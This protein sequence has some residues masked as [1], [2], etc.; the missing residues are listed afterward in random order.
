MQSMHIITNVTSSNPA[1]AMYTQYNNRHY[2][3]NFVMLLATEGRR[4]R[5]RTVVGLKT[6]YAISAYHHRCCKFESSSGEVYSIQ[7]YVI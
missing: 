2:V 3:I 4:G 1:H 7:H 5:D 6:I